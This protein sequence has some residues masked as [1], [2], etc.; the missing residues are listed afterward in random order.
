[1]VQRAVGLGGTVKHVGGARALRL[2]RAL[3]HAL[4]HGL[5]HV[6]MLR[7]GLLL[8]LLLLLLRPLRCALPRLRPAAA[9]R[10]ALERLVRRLQL[11]R[12]RAPTKHVLLQVLEVR[13]EAAAVQLRCLRG[14]AVAAG[15]RAGGGAGAGVAQACEQAPARPWPTLQAAAPQQQHTATSSAHLADGQREGGCGGKLAGLPRGPVEPGGRRRRAA[16]PAVGA[17]QAV[18]Q[19]DCGRWGSQWQGRVEP[20]R[21]AIP[22]AS[23]PLPGCT[24]LL[25]CR[26]ACLSGRPFPPPPPPPPPPPTHRAPAPVSSR[27]AMSWAQGWWAGRTMCTGTSWA[28]W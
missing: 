15:A 27:A 8:L 14:A 13:R 21:L 20:P 7:V 6:S 17:V 12:R 26:S 5:R 25:G 18:T 23:L 3:L 4:L 1:M 2:L 10:Q 28:G 24:C 22:R 16:Q 19:L 11:W 9:Q